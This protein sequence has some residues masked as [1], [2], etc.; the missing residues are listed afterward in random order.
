[1]AYKKMTEVC[2]GII[3]AGD[4]CE[5][6]SG[7][8]LMQTPNS[9]VIAVMRRNSAKAKD[10]AR[11]HHISKWYDNADDLINDTAINAIYIATPPDTHAAYTLKA[12]AAGKAIYVEKPMARTH[13]EC[14]SM[15]DA[16]KKANVPLFVAYYRRAMPNILKVKDLID[17]G[18]IGTVRS[19]NV[20]LQMPLQSD[21]IGSGSNSHNWRIIP[22]IAGGGYFFDLASHQLNAL[23]FLFGPIIKA[24]GMSENQSEIYKAK[25]ITVGLFK[26]ENGIL[27]SGMWAFNTSKVSKNELTTIIGSEG[28]ISFSFFGDNSVVLKL[29]NKTKKEFQYDISKHVQKYLIQT[30]VDELLGKGK[31]PSNGVSGARTNWVMEQIY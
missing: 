9:K 18:S 15:V 17:K 13:K 23:D 24:T 8:A 11:R 31:C 14:I 6:K 25:D 5:V 22:E 7:P 27:G 3:G 10:F 29:N 28:Q 1:M 12:A 2:W 30:I 19:V 16:C 4:V 21:D 20:N 26:F